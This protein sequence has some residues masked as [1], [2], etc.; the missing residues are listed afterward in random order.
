MLMPR[1]DKTGIR[2]RSGRKPRKSTHGYEEL[3]MPWH[4]N[5]SANGYIR[6]HVWVMS[7][8]I[9]GPVPDGYQ[10][11]HM[12]GNKTNNAPS[13]LMLCTPTDHT[14]MHIL[15][16]AF[17]SCGN[18]H[19]RKCRFCGKYDDTSAMVTHSGGWAH[20]ECRSISWQSRKSRYQQV[21]TNDGK[22]SMRLRDDLRHTARF[23]ERSYW[24]A[25]GHILVL[26]LLL[27]P[28]HSAA[29]DW[30]LDPGPIANCP[31]HQGVVIVPT[32]WQI[33]QGRKHRTILHP[34]CHPITSNDWKR[35][36]EAD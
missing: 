22:F 12:D 20:K 23:G 15:M 36:H 4:P 25:A 27:N 24:K 6:T 5:S 7:R 26:L 11:H 16:D 19:W 1:K 34:P 9:G 10:V 29:R 14:R 31:N 13:N 2:F 33:E 35:R 17:A 18:P 32:D 8:M 21:R 30:V 3:Y 28:V